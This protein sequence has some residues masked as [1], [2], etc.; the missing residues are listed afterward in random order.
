MPRVFQN[1]SRAQQDGK[2]TY[3]LPVAKEILELRL[4][5]KP[6]TAQQPSVCPSRIT[7]IRSSSLQRRQARIQGARVRV[8][9]A[10]TPVLRDCPWLGVWPH[11][12]RGALQA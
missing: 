8:M 12:V 4:A 7:V 1:P 11:I 5:N 10:I 6:F 9:D 2:T 3:L